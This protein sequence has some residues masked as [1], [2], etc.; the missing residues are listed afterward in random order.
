MALVDYHLYYKFI[1][2]FSLNCL[3]HFNDFYYRDSVNHYGLFIAEDD[4]AVD[5]DFPCLDSREVVSKFGFTYLALVERDQAVQQE[6]T[7]PIL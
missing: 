4:G 1:M 3:F 2:S 7:Y 6:E 5:W